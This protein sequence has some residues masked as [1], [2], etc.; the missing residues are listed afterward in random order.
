MQ[1]KHYP[2][3]PNWDKKKQNKGIEDILDIDSHCPYLLF[4]ETTSHLT[5]FFLNVENG[6]KREMKLERIRFLKNKMCLHPP[7]PPPRIFFLTAIFFLMLEI[8]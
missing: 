7:P 3:P 4:G 6:I 8:A 1:E 5:N 2:P